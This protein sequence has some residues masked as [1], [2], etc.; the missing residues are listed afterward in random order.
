M[1]AGSWVPHPKFISSYMPQEIVCGLFNALAS[2]CMNYLLE[3]TL[4]VTLS[5]QQT[6]FTPR[7]FFF[8]SNG[9]II[10]V[11][12]GNIMK[13][14][15]KTEF[16]ARCSWLDPIQLFLVINIVKSLTVSS[17]L[18]LLHSS[19]PRVSIVSLQHPRCQAPGCPPRAGGSNCIPT[20]VSAAKV[21]DR[22]CPLLAL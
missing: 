12:A 3:R 19:A 21:R 20:Q 17:S 13:F 1:T 5:M 11:Y 6:S 16:N 10:A 2:L 18:W 15:N 4:V 14:R 9:D 22:F 7:S 8:L